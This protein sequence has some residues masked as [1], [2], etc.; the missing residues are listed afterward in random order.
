MRRLLLAAV[1][2]MLAGQAL[3]FEAI[4]PYSPPELLECWDSGLSW[5]DEETGRCLFLSG[6]VGLTAGWDSQAGLLG[7]T[8]GK[9]RLGVVVD[10]TMGLAA[11]MGVETE[12]AFS[13]GTSIFRL[14]EAYVQI[15]TELR[16]RVGYFDRTYGSLV[17]GTRIEPI[18][19]LRPFIGT[20]FAS[21]YGGGLGIQLLADVGAWS[22][23]VSLEDVEGYDNSYW[24]WAW[25]PQPTPPGSLIAKAS[26][27]D[28]MIA[29]KIVGQAAGV[30][31]GQ[32]DFWSVSGSFLFEG[33]VGDLLLFGGIDEDNAQYG[34]TAKAHLGPGYIT[35]TVSG[36]FDENV[37]GASIGI[38]DRDVGPAIDL[39]G[40]AYIGSQIV[41]QIQLTGSVVPVENLRVQGAIGQ[42]SDAWFGP[43]TYVRGSVE[44]RPTTTSELVAAGE[45]NDQGAAKATLKTTQHF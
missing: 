9:A 45:V 35:V 19:I 6:Y 25:P 5:S 41:T 18:T 23:G 32:V 34:A 27:D 10:Q 24:Y 33:E 3:G 37:L 1:A 28:G 4:E 39:S 26:Y 38:G 16:A 21:V 17:N 36:T 8:G 43:V 14:N 40:Q 31:D 20:E 30:L 12:L 44:W 29:A 22:F 15:G 42:F 11:A 2:A 13:N 7:S